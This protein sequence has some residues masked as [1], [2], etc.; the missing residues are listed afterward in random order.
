MQLE[1][2]LKFNFV[3]F[4]FFVFGEMQGFNILFFWQFHYPTP[5]F[6]HKYINKCVRCFLADVFIHFDTL[7]MQIG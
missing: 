3:T 1:R 4:L 6:D 2:K 7:M 5:L